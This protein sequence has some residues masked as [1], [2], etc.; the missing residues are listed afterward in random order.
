MS[1]FLVEQHAQRGLL[2][3]HREDD[4]VLWSDTLDVRL[5]IKTMFAKTDTKEMT[6]D[7]SLDMR[8]RMLYQQLEN[9]FARVLAQIS[10]NY[11][12]QGEEL[13]IR[14][15]DARRDILVHGAVISAKRGTACIARERRT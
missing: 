2:I 14:R 8:W 10:T 11:L 4:E 15:C 13:T 6:G 5:C 7:R 12:G 9:S 3:F 1:R